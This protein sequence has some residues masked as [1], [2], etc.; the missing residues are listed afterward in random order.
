VACVRQAF[1]STGNEYY[2]QGEPKASECVQ[3]GMSL[4]ESFQASGVVPN[5]FVE[6]VSIG[7]LSG[8]ETES[9]ERLA[10]EYD[11]RAK[12]AMSQLC[13]AASTAIAIATSLLIIFLIIRMAM[14][15]VA[16]LQSFM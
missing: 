14:Q 4:A 5:E 9:L 1:Y 7:E 8:N 16:M 12:V 3:Q 13:V 11:R 6:G 10:A 15:Y 2:I